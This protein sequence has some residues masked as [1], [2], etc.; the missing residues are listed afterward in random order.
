M[1]RR[2]FLCVGAS[3]L[4]L[5]CTGRVFAADLEIDVDQLSASRIPLCREC[6]DWS[7]RKTQDHM[8]AD[9]WV[10]HHPSTRP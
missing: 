7:E 2:G 9:K 6:L 3:G 4:S 5:S 10:V 8:I 1:L